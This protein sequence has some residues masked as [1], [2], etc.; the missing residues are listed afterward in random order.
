MSTFFLDNILFYNMPEWRKRSGYFVNS[1]RSYD[2]ILK[3]S[4]CYCE[5]GTLIDED[6]FENMLV[7]YKEEIKKDAIHLED[8]FFHLTNDK[9]EVETI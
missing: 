6:T 5:R 1:Y 9:S 8:V 7:K 2:Q 3:Y 4:N